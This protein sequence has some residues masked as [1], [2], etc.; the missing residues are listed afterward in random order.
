MQECFRYIPDG[1]IQT[2]LGSLGHLAWH[3]NWLIVALDSSRGDDLLHSREAVTN[4]LNEGGVRFWWSDE[5]LWVLGRDIL[6]A[7]RCRVLVPFSAT[8][9]FQNDVRTVERPPYSLTSESEIF[10]DSAPTSLRDFVV[11]SG[12]RGY[13]ADG[14]GLNYFFVDIP[15]CKALQEPP[16]R[17][18]DPSS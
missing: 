16:S 7:S 12:T 1:N 14:C 4:L 5:G 17:E 8:Y 3:Y 15:L 18:A 9:L 6:Q 13:L 2:A 10:T 11:K